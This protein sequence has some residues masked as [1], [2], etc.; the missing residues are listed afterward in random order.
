VYVD[1]VVLPLQNNHGLEVVTSDLPETR[2][3]D[4]FLFEENSAPLS[5]RYAVL[6]V[7]SN[8]CPGRLQEKFGGRDKEPIV[9]VKGWIADVDSLYTAWLA[10]YGALP[11]TIASSPGTEVEIWATLLTRSQ[12][13]TM[14]QSENLGDDYALVAVATPLCVGTFSIHNVY[15]YYDRRLLCL[16][17]ELVRVADFEARNAEFRAMSEREVLIAV[18]DRLGFCLGAPIDRRHRE[19]TANSATIQAINARLVLTHS[20]CNNP[21]G[22]LSPVLPR[23]LHAL[24]WSTR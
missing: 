15:A 19:L 7:G 5:S 23:E 6:A 16:D 1:G 13:E 14:N 21:R 24:R 2:Q 9:V 8:A 20:A 10:D 17:G 4:D 3:V 12:L 22:V 18:L 11:A